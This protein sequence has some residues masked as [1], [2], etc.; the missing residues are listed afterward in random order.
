MDALI[1]LKKLIFLLQEQFV[2][3]LALEHR[4]PVTT[5]FSS[6]I[7]LVDAIISLQAI[8]GSSGNI[9]FNLNAEIN[10]NNKIDIAE[11]ISALQ[12]AAETENIQ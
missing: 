10:N 7:D 2:T 12:M 11:A 8:T 9:S 1:T 5:N 3:A 4:I 6:S